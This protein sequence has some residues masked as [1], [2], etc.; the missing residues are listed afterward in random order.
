M[1]LL[2]FACADQSP[3]AHWLTAAARAATASAV[4]D[5]VLRFAV[6]LRA[7]AAPRRYRSHRSRPRGRLSL[8][9]A[10]AAAA[11]VLPG[12]R[13]A[14]SHPVWFSLLSV[15]SLSRMLPGSGGVA[16][17]TRGLPSPPARRAGEVDLA[18]GRR[19]GVGVAV[20]PGAGAGVGARATAR[21]STG[22][23]GAAVGAAS[24]TAYAA[25]YRLLTAGESVAGAESTAAE[26]PALPALLAPEGG[27]F[28]APCWCSLEALMRHGECAVE[29]L[30]TATG[31]RLFP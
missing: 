25:A 30:H 2:A 21:T 26:S 10:A 20:G 9:P 17:P 3:A 6:A 7:G 5:V 23:Q 16:A 15:L 1:S 28:A 14:A 12:P 4:N 18:A 11:P 22:T 19:R 24:R 29:A 31:A 8:S 13:P 27:V